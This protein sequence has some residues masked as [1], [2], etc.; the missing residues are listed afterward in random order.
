M[1]AP[2]RTYIKVVYDGVDITEAVENTV[3]DFIYVDQAS[4]EANEI[5][6][7]CHDREGNWHNDWYPKPGKKGDGSTGSGSSDYSDMAQALQQGVSATELQRM[8][9]AS[10]LTAEQGRTLQR[11]TESSSWPQFA[12]QNPQYRGESGKVKLIEDIKSGVVK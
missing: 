3:I 4:N 10:D 1:A 2:R 8:I 6:L 9:D 11:V 5:Q 7:N 12:A